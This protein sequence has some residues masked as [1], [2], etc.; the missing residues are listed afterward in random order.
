[1]SLTK[2]LTKNQK[3][4]DDLTQKQVNKF[5]MNEFKVNF[6][7]Q[8]LSD[9]KEGIFNLSSAKDEMDTFM[10]I[11]YMR[12]FHNNYEFESNHNGTNYEIMFRKKE[13]AN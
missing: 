13:V 4:I 5:Q 6:V 2:E 3:L 1:M 8:T 10:A 7:K 12:K 11:H 9:Y